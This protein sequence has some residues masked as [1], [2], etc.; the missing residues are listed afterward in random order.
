MK[1]NMP[2]TQRELPL[3]DTLQIVSKTDLKGKITF[4][5]RDFIEVSGFVEDELIGVNHNIVRHPDMPPEAFADLWNTVKNGKPWIG[6]VKNRCKNGDHY[7]VEAV[8]SP[9][10]ENGQVAGYIS[11][12]KKATRQ[13]IEGALK[14]HQAIRGEQSVYEKLVGKYRNF[15]R[16]ISLRNR[17]VSIF[18]V[19][20][21][22]SL[23]IGYSGLTSLK[24]SDDIVGVLYHDHV[25]PIKE[26]KAVSDMYAVNVVDT[27]HK[28]NVGA[29]SW[30]A[31]EANLTEALKNVDAQWQAYKLH[32]SSELDKNLAHEIELLMANAN[33][34]A[35]DL[36]GI[37]RAQDPERLQRFT[38]SA[39]YP[40]I[41]P[42]STKIS[43]LIDTQ[44]KEAEA[45]HEASE[46]VYE[47]SRN[48]IVFIFVL[49]ALIAGWLGKLLYSAIIPR[50]NAAVRYLMLSSQGVEHESVARYGYR[51]EMTDVMDAYRALRTRLDFDNAETLAGVDRIKSALDNASIPVT[52]GSDTNKLIYM[53]KAGFA[54]WEKMRSEIAKRHPGFTVDKLIG[55]TLGQYLENEQDRAAYTAPF[56]GTKVLN[57]TMAGRY[58]QLTFNAVT[59]TE[60]VYLGRMIQWLDRTDEVIAEQQVADLIE[61][62]VAGNLNQR[63]DLAGLPAGF[64]T[65]VSGGMN[66]LLEAVIN[67]L[68]M[69]ADYVDSLSKGV[70]PAEITEE[71]RGD[72]NIIKNNL[73]ACGHAIKALVSDANLL[74]ESAEA[75]VL[76]VRADAA[77]HLGEYRNVIKGLNATLDAIV[78]PL[79][80]AADSV[81]RIARGEIPDMLTEKYQGDFNYLKDNLN[82]CFKAINALIADV[83][84]LSDAANQ[85]RVSVRADANAHEGDFRKIVDGVNETLEM[86]VGPIATVKGAVETINTAA[87]EIAQGNADLSRRTEDQAASLEKTAASMEELSSTVKQNADN[88][89]QANQLATAASDVAV[90]G[91][92]AVAEVVTTMADINDSAKK[93]EDIISV[94]DGIAF[95][96]NIL[97]LNA[98]VEAARAG[99]QGRGFA[100]V[101][102]EVRSLAQ[103]SAT[104][105]KEIKALITDSV[106]KTAEG[107]VQ[108]ENAGKTMQEIVTSVKRVTDIIGEISAASQEQSAGIAQVNEAI[109]KM[110]DVTQQNTALVEE[111]AAAAESMMEQAD[112]LMHAVSVF[113]LEG[114]EATRPIGS[115]VQRV[116]NKTGTPVVKATPAKPATRAGSDDG[117]WEEF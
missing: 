86:I 3:K 9:V 57:M 111:A 6:I 81:E 45:L 88:A 49:G 37:L 112:E 58:L 99:E 48:F 22:F 17:I 65:E 31:G 27:A 1:I 66:R 40:A 8:V 87:K 28:V 69:A 5:N 59:N 116:A 50:V 85:G 23:L 76:N 20:V 72:F 10:V 14:F 97:A 18:F 105:A 7:W 115:R 71:Y 33:N 41:D 11:V 107:T 25:V 110:D 35:I 21:L 4:V 78:K 104:A 83:Q 51:D 73:N 47:N 114:E 55:G 13:Q 68:N 70:I 98:A 24:T 75:G 63:I 100:V 82:T 91:G 36:Q 93:I 94:I 101:A 103:R 30:S 26:L 34:A 46:V 84:V 15:K 44:L 80:M 2:V 62:T 38:S 64:I 102:G 16:S 61:S 108:V 42:V 77:Q 32:P 60:G 106:N 109:I 113:Q 95:Q 43:A 54:L 19:V 56:T 12:R 96:T 67:P 39:L 53:N 89:K 74:A 90:K 79:N 52:V 92:N 117:D 29:L